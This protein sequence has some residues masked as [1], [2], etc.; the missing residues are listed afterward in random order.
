MDAGR[1]MA[2]IHWEP[3]AQ[4]VVRQKLRLG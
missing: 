4:S 3:C 1:K 2:R